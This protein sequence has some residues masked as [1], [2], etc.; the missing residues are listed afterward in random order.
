MKQHDVANNLGPE[1]DRPHGFFARLRV[2]DFDDAGAKRVLDLLAKLEISEDEP[3]ERDLARQLWYLPLFCLWQEERVVE[4]KGN[5]Q[6]LR[7][8]LTKATNVLEDKI[9]VP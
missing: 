3:L 2:G 8:F 9:G 1:W 4:E 7:A 5:V 6:A